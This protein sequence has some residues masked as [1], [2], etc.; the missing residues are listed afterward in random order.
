LTADD[1][2][3]AALE[4]IREGGLAAVAVEPL[5]KRLGATKGSF[6]WHFSHREALIDAVLS[7]WEKRNIEVTA[8]AI[9]AAAAESAPAERLRRFF[10]EVPATETGHPVEV[11]MLAAADHPQ[12]LPV[13]KRVIRRRIDLIAGLF[14]DIGFSREEA[15]RRGLMIYVYYVGQMAVIHAVPSVLPA[16]QDRE[17]YLDTLTYT[18]T[19]PD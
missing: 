7:R 3:D 9:E 16:P 5:A 15:R 19:R 8:A 18:F 14:V 6:Y 4:A 17:S 13:L 2:V 10:L 1:W 11:A 12:V